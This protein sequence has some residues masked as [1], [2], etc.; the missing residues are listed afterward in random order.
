M[1]RTAFTQNLDYVRYI[2]AAKD[3]FRRCL[4]VFLFRRTSFAGGQGSAKIFAADT[5]CPPA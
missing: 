1:Q 5:W 4:N 2:V 3:A